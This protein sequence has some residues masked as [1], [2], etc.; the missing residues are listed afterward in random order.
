MDSVLPS[1]K[2]R[3]D[4]TAI[5]S[6]LGRKLTSQ[7]YGKETLIV[8]N[9]L[10]LGYTKPQIE[11]AWNFY[12]EKGRII[13]SF[14]FFLYNKADAMKKIEG[15]LEMKVVETVQPEL[16]LTQDFRTIKEV[17]K[18]KPTLMEFF[19]NENKNLDKK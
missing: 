18:T 1:K 12:K 2:F 5:L 13:N 6:L 7:E 10:K 15:L 14:A 11:I 17:P 19:S 9:I 8:K 3:S 16:D 4:F